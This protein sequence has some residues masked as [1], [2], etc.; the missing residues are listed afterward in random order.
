MPDVAV[1]SCSA[2]P[3]K[4]PRRPSKSSLSIADETTSSGVQP[5]KTKSLESSKRK[6]KSSEQVSDAELQAASALLR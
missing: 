5:S 3:P 4:T 1:A 6:R 2:A